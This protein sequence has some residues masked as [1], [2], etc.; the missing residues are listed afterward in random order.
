MKNSLCECNSRVYPAGGRISAR[1]SGNRKIQMEANSKK[2]VQT[3]QKN[4][5]RNMVNTTSR[6]M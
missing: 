1:N 4:S 6:Y 5:I 2:N 3:K